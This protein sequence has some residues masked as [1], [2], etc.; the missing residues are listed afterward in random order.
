[1]PS[2][3]P[4]C[5]DVRSLLSEGSYLVEALRDALLDREELIGV[6]IY[7]VLGRRPGGPS[8]H[9]SCWTCE[10]RPVGQS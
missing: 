6:E 1:M 7:E 2:W 4:L 8:T 9:G 5:D 10:G 3:M